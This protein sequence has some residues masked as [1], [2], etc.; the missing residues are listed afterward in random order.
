MRAELS[1]RKPGEQVASPP[2]FHM[3]T[4]PRGAIC[5]LDCEY[6][7]FLSK[8][9][10]YPGS[11][12]RMS[13]ELLEIYIRKYIEAQRVSEITFAWQ[14]GEPTLMGLDFFR[15]AVEL[16]G[17]YR[18]PGMTIQNSL[19]T[20]GLLLDE[21]WAHFFARNQFLVGVSLDGPPELHDV[22]RKDKGGNPTHARVMKAIVLLRQNRVDFNI[23]CCVQAANARRSLEVYRFLRDEARTNFIQ[24]IPI[25]ERENE[26]GFQEGTRVSR[27][28]ISPWDYGQFLITIFE[29]WV[30]NDV[31]KVFVQMFDVC[32]GVWLGH[33]SS[34]CVHAETCGLA[35]ALEHNG[36]LYSCD[37][38]VEPNYFLG[39]I[40][41]EDLLPLVGSKQQVRFGRAKKNDLPRYCQECEVR[42]ICNGGCPKDRIRRT[43]SGE[44]GLNFLCEGYKAFF[45]H[46]D[47]KMKL[48]AALIKLGRPPAD[49]I[50]ILAGQES[51][52]DFAAAPAPAPAR[53]RK[54]RSSANKL[55]S[56]P[57]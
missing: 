4:K 33:P 46:I 52:H 41:E 45:T 13:P 2:A 9:K 20:N 10:L 43:P 25:V 40:R 57:E 47:E 26:T 11:N 3:M 30:R 27:R 8:E 32:L 39:N 36:D 34:L 42:F 7:Y 28:S 17:K 31:G 18:R 22:Y 55:G 37:H 56:S 19:Q 50:G 51:A 16:Q 35:L 44:P 14:G 48:M 21:E 15:R 6:C 38:F 54:R 24:F 29:E 5:N 23:L 12:F 53:Q 1:N 49:I